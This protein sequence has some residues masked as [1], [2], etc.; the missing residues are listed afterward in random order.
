MTEV[1]NQ[2]R[3]NGGHLINEMKN[4]SKDNIL[5]MG[6]SFVSGEVLGMNAAGTH[7]VKLDLD[8]TATDGAVAKGV[9]F[10]AVDASAAEQS[11]LAH[12]RICSVLA[13]HLT[14]PDAITDARKA[15]FIDELLEAIIIPR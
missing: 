13:D 2:P 6:G 11:G 7:Y 9:L 8:D 15:E 14:W 10:G 5:L 4:V 3:R 1:F 12:T